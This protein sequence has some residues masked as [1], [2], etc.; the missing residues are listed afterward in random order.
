MQ[1]VICWQTCACSNNG[2]TIN[3]HQDLWFLSD[4]LNFVIFSTGPDTWGEHT[5]DANGSQQSPVNIVPSDAEFDQA[6]KDRPLKW[7][8]DAKQAQKLVNTGRS[9]QV[10]Y[11][12]EGS[13]RLIAIIY[14]Y[15]HSWSTLRL[16]YHSGHT[17]RTCTLLQF[18][19][20][21]HVHE[22]WVC[23]WITLLLMLNL[24]Q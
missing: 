24:L 11:N 2:I 6:L 17:H 13:C 4:K 10:I 16:I 18:R 22:G 1:N 5:P 20:C 8:Y 23:R 7:T 19:S 14:L 3:Y 21:T 9:I 12:S 15:S